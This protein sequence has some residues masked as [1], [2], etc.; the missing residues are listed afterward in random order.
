MLKKL[1]SLVV[2]L[3]LAGIASA[4][5]T[6]QWNNSVPVGAWEDSTNWVTSSGASLPPGTADFAAP[7]PADSGATTNPTISLSSTQSCGRIK[8]QHN[9]AVLNIN[10]GGELINNGSVGSCQMYGGTAEII[11]IKN[12][13]T[14]LAEGSGT[15]LQTGSGTHT[16]NVQSGGLLSVH[17]STGYLANSAL[18]L[19]TTSSGGGF[20]TVNVLSGGILD[21]DSIFIANTN[22]I[23]NLNA[24]GTIYVKGTVSGSIT[25][26]GGTLQITS[27]VTDPVAGSPLNGQSV[28]QYTV[29]PEPATLALLGLGGLLLRRKR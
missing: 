27:G 13:G 4:V 14:F 25:P 12:G 23:I 16:I 11:N 3:A 1:V 21:A 26:V 17:G 20:A 24:G 28:T 29:I 6:A 5:A 2:V 19:G 18:G 10:N 9:S 7:Y 22:Q 15:G 8:W